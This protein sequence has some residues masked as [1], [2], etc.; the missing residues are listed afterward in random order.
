MQPLVNEFFHEASGT[1]SYLV[2][3]PATHDAAV[4]DAVLDYEPRTARTSTQ[5]A[6]RI[7]SHAREK[8]LRVRWVL[9][10]HAHADHVSAGAYLRD[11]FA[12]Q[13]AIGEGVKKVQATFKQIFNLGE[14]FKTDGSQFDRLFQDG[15]SF[16]IGT[17]QARV[18]AMPG[19]TNDSIAYVVGDCAFIGD[20][21]FAPDVGSARCDFPGGDARVLYASVQKL[22]QLPESTRLF[23]CHDY[24]PGARLRRCEVS[25]AEQRLSNLHLRDG[26]TADQ[27]VA[28]RVA[29]DRGLEAPNLILPAIQMNLRGGRKPPPEANGTSYLKLPV[30]TL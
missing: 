13:L 20:T 28:M 16:A 5:F 27:F 25:V 3:D 30:D 26:I 23:L 15:D 8:N 4:I 24:P 11:I 7:V 14:E 29:R 9:E 6:D 21:L 17:L 22:Y 19:H 2:A 18:L 1:F 10:T 12:A